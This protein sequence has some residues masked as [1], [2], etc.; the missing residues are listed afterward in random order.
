[1]EYISV[2]EAAKKRGVSE[3]SM[4]G[5][6]A[7]GRISGAFLTGKTWNIPDNTVK[8]DRINKRIETPKTLLEVLKAEKAAKLHGG[9]Y[10]GVRINGMW[11]NKADI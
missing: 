5:Y 7:K 2:A 11:Q 3:R 1:M 9:I 8:P 4:R 6:C 10:Q